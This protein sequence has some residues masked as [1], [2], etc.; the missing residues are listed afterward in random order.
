MYSQ[1]KTGAYVLDEVALASMKSGADCTPPWNA[2]FTSQPLNFSSGNATM[3]KI[4][5]GKKC[6]ENHEI[7]KAA[8]T[9]SSQN[10]DA[11]GVNS[12]L[13]GSYQNEDEATKDYVES[14]LPEISGMCADSVRTGSSACKVPW[15][16]CIDLGC[17][18]LIG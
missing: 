1:L 2:N 10:S 9:T 14:P 13:I 18:D 12:E 15:A 3:P 4:R 8:L 16:L 5:A 6:R 11:T 7:C 17:D